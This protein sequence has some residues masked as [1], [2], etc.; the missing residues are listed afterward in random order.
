MRRWFH[1]RGIYPS[2]SNGSENNNPLSSPNHTV[3]FLG[4]I[5]QTVLKITLAF[6]VSNLAILGQRT[7]KVT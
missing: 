3:K 1:Q 2:D 4:K 7:Q 5:K 6:A